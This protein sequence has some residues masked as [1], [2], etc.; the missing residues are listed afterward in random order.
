MKSLLHKFVRTMLLVSAIIGLS[1]LAIVT[2]TSIQASSEYL[3]TIRSHIQDGITAKGK[4]LTQNH[5]IALRQLVLDNAFNDLRQ[6]VDRAVEGDKDVVYGIYVNSGK[7]TLAYTSRT[8]ASSL[9]DLPA[10]DAF[11]AIG[12]SERDVIVN[13][14]SVRQVVLNGEELV[15]VAEPVRGEDHEVLGTVRYGLSTRRMNQALVSAKND[16]DARLGR[17]LVLIGTLV[18]LATLLGILL[19]RI[20][21]VRIT[22]PVRELT[23]AAN[24]L[25]SGD[26][27]VRVVVDS[28][29]EL[30]RLGAAFNHMV[31]DLNAS[32]KQLELMNRTLEEKVLDR[33][34]ELGQRNRDMRLVLDNVDQGFVTLSLDSKMARE[35][36]RVFDVWFGESP[37]E[38]RFSDY[39][40]RASRTF[41]L[42]FELAWEQIAEDF[43]PLELCI[44]QLPK[45][46]SNEKGTW[47]FRY[48]PIM[49][50][51][52]LEGVL[53]VAS[54]V[55]ERLAREREEAEQ[56]E[57]MQG[58]K[59]LMLDR[60]GFAAF[61]REA[62][63]MV[64]AV[65]G[66]RLENDLPALKR[67]LHTLKGNAGAMGLTVVARIVH[68][69]EEQMLE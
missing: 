33:T 20:Q 50:E 8:A 10:R 2:W 55:S 18:T 3:S 21:A 62:T 9:T 37:D 66:R 45:R 32:Y 15:E 17:S 16:S 24:K 30:E 14:E 34:R 29:D 43:L 35:R 54:E 57:L 22:Q 12:L 26:R 5:A 36:S 13:E 25:A 7:T 68:S 19:S 61:Q 67:T 6:L 63:S 69:I 51:G 23:D 28:G 47:F 27:E 53:V 46:F 59:R 65:F 38:P 49:P 42:E 44:D 11:T 58:F 56:Q 41:G 48:L 52:H 64:N 4:V 31:E 40:K 39:M 1:S 60:S